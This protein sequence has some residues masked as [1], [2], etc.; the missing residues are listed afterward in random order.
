MFVDD[1]DLDSYSK[2][3]IFTH[4]KD[5]FLDFVDSEGNDDEENKIGNER[6]ED[7]KYQKQYQQQSENEKGI[8][9]KK[10]EKLPLFDEEEKANHSIYKNNNNEMLDDGSQKVIPL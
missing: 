7:I 8:Q 4:L 3:N 10:D 2:E 5:K 9:Q 1:K 6:M